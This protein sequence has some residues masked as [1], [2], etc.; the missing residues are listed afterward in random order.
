[1]GVDVDGDAY[2]RTIAALESRT[3]GEVSNDE[4]QDLFKCLLA[5]THYIEAAH[6]TTDTQRGGLAEWARSTPLS[7]HAFDYANLSIS[8]AGDAFRALQ[9]MVLKG[10]G[11]TPLA[12]YTLGRQAAESAALAWWCLHDPSP[13]GLATTGLAVAWQDTKDRINFLEAVNAAS[14]VVR[15]RELRRELLL[16]GRAQRLLDSSGR[17]R[18][19]QPK[20]TELFG[21]VTFGDDDLVWFYRCLSGAAHSRGWAQ[22][23]MTKREEMQ[24]YV[25][26]SPEGRLEP[27][28]VV[29]VQSGPNTSLLGSLLLVSLW[30][31]DL[32][33]KQRDLAHSLPAPKLG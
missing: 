20:W 33:L 3:T 27:T 5:A 25:K 21:K 24:S 1:M 31:L 11:L 13:L 29:V 28:G 32:A 23:S 8:A 2:R 19:A 26:F 30:L 22:L 12:G 14:E 17:P 10:E 7:R 4:G 18:T 6:S 15:A 16:N 9:I